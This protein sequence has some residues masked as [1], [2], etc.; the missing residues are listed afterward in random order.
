MRST[1][2]L[3]ETPH[4]GVFSFRAV[5]RM[6][7][8]DVC[9]Q[10]VEPTIVNIARYNRSGMRLCDRACRAVEIREPQLNNVDLAVDRRESAFAIFG[11]S[12]WDE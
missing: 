7:S 9:G 12:F 11:D 4:E 6:V 8:C 10:P 5:T 1:Q 2:S 3:T